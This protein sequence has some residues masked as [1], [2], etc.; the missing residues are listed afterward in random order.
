V[1][2]LGYET[3]PPPEE[4]IDGE[5]KVNTK[6]YDER[7]KLLYNDGVQ[8][9]GD[10]VITD[11]YVVNSA[12]YAVAKAILEKLGYSKEQFSEILRFGG[13]KAYESNIAAIDAWGKVNAPITAAD[14]VHNERASLI[15]GAETFGDSEVSK[16]FI[17]GTTQTGYNPDDP[18]VKG[19]V[20]PMASQPMLN[21]WNLKEVVDYRYWEEKVWKRDY[22]GLAGNIFG[23]EVM[24]SKRE[25]SKKYWGLI[26]IVHTHPPGYNDF[27][28][29]GMNGSGG[30]GG[31]AAMGEAL[32]VNVYM[33]TTDTDNDTPRP[34][35]K[36]LHHKD[37]NRLTGMSSVRGATDILD[38]GKGADNKAL[39]N[40]LQE[41]EFKNR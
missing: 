9:E 28:G 6:F 34:Q 18:A 25:I 26:S 40:R 30:Y 16:I 7:G 11:L 33:I 39:I 22:K 15:F 37:V 32:K 41:L 3:D 5:D 4:M 27:S 31:D 35:I 21:N 13:T 38:K 2:E 23:E 20:D 14:K 17:L 12:Y 1:D 29:W 24:E 36:I 19:I 10:D 8:G